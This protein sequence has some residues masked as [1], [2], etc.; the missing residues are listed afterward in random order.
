M[1]P[2]TSVDAYP[3]GAS[4]FGVMDLVGN[5]WQWTDE[6]VDEHTRAGIVQRR[7]LLSAARL[8]LVL[9]RRPTS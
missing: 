9:S 8:A 4:P 5:V 6:F 2:P 7:K 3:Q 1:R